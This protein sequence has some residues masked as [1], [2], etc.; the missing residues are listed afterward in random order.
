[1]A[2]ASDIIQVADRD[3]VALVRIRSSAILSEAEV[4]AFGEALAAL[5]EMPVRRIVVSF[6]GVH[7]LTS[8]VLGA[9]IRM[10]KLL[11]ESGGDLRL[12]DIEPHVY[13]MFTITRL[14][15]MFRIFER[16][17][18]AVASFRSEAEA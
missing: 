8:L 10:K 9:L 7:H 18:E 13:E 6:L 16:G 12:A 15:R 5:A 3:G 11:A 2:E 17:D 1:M 14:D 4:E